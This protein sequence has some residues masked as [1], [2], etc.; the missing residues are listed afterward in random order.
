V[1][2][3]DDVDVPLITGQTPA[4]GTE[5]ATGELVDITLS[6]GPN[7][8]GFDPEETIISQ[9]ANSPTITQLIASMS[10]Y[11]DPTA[12]LVAFYN[13][14]WNID[15]AVG[16]GLDTWGRIVG[17]SRL[18]QLPYS[19]PTF[20]FYTGDSS[21]QPFNQ[22]PFSPGV[23]ATQTFSLP[24]APY[25]TLILVKAFGNIC[26]PT[27]PA[28]NT[29]LNNLFEGRGRCYVQDYG[30]MAMS[31]AF[32]FTLTPVEYA[33]LT[34]VGVPPRPAGVEV[35]I[36]QVNQANTFG[37]HGTGLQPFNQAPFY[38]GA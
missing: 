4:A 32:E 3:T 18:L 7:P 30:G 36:V 31:Y 16:F 27:A 20:G 22:A 14:V 10:D 8:T 38:A 19:A 11:F 5:L 29:M 26:R 21:F 34:Q 23:N 33:I 17:V 28:I 35:F 24:D 12:N 1:S 25:R 9:Y 2:S 15:S 6:L 37:F 13:N